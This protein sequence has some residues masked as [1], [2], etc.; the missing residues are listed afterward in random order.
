MRWITKI[1]EAT[2]QGQLDLPC[3]DEPPPEDVRILLAKWLE[4]HRIRRPTKESSAVVNLHYADNGAR[5]EPPS[6]RG[7]PPS[8][9]G[10]MY[11]G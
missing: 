7:E 3:Y 11:G 4:E 5:G 6:S 10:K 9:R 2:A 8:S 1:A